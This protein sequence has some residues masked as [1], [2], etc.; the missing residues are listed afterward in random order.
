MPQYSL[1]EYKLRRYIYLGHCYNIYV[2]RSFRN[3]F[4][5]NEKFHDDF[6]G[7]QLIG[8]IVQKRDICKINSIV[9]ILLKVGYKPFTN[10]N[11]YVIFFSYFL[12]IP[13]YIMKI[14]SLKMNI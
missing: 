10:H 2:P 12:I 9:P 13:R 1:L 5:A 3:S 11:H 4:W 8:K 6:I 14:N 7:V